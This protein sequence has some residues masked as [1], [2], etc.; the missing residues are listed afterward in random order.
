MTSHEKA[1]T[2]D[3]SPAGRGETRAPFFMPSPVRV[4][5]SAD[6]AGV[7]PT[8]RRLNVGTGL[9]LSAPINLTI[10][11]LTFLIFLHFAFGLSYLFA[12]PAWE[13]YDEPF[14]FGYAARI[15][16]QGTLPQETDNPVNPERIQPP[17]YY[18]GLAS[19]LSASGSD[20]SAYQFPTM[21]PFFYYSSSGN[22]YALHPTTLS[23]N[24]RRI[25]AALFFSRIVS[26]L[27]SLLGIPLVYLAAKLIWPSRQGL[28]LA[29]AAIFALWPQY[30]FNGSMVTNDG[31]TAV[32]G[33]LLTYT[34]I[35]FQL[36]RPTI[37][38]GLICL[39][40][41]IVG[42]FVK[43]N[44]LTL[45]LPLAI[46]ILLTASPRLI[47]LFVGIGTVAVVAVIALLQTLP[48]ILLPFFKLDAHGETILIALWHRLGSNGKPSLVTDS[49]NYALQ[50]SF[51]LFGWGNIALP[52]WLQLVWIGGVALAFAGLL[53]LIFRQRR[54]MRSI[55]RLIV[56]PVFILVALI[57]GGLA[58]SLF[59]GT[60]HLLPGRYLLPALSAF[61]L[62]LV[63]G[64]SGF[65]K[66]VGRVLIGGTIAGLFVLGVVVPWHFLA[67]F[68]APPPVLAAGEPIP[69]NNP[70]EIAPGAELVGYTVPP[71]VLYP[72][73][74]VAVDVY[75]RATRPIQTDYTVRIEWVGYDGQGYGLKD[76]YP[77]NG[78][79]P[80]S[81]WVPNAIFRDRYT[82][83]V[84]ED[85]PAP[86][87]GHFKITLLTTDFT[88]S[89]ELTE[90]PLAVHAVQ[91]PQLTL[92]NQI[93]ARFGD[94]VLLRSASMQSDTERTLSIDALWQATTVPIED[95]TLFVHLEDSTG[96]PVAQQDEP[97]LGGAFPLSR[98]LANEAVSDHYTL[99][100][101]PTAPAGRYA[102]RLGFFDPKTMLRWPVQ[103]S[104]APDFVELGW[105]W[106]DEN[107]NLQVHQHYS[108]RQG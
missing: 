36:K 71:A 54:T 79:H 3:P 24:A 80:T 93:D 75:W 13:A 103:N 20:V 99:V 1:L 77:R 4:A 53:I 51:G 65:G 56:V 97:P 74:E 9:A 90:T 16:S 19:L 88:G 66:R 7:V 58:L 18:L 89:A 70:R 73:D 104:T 92:P 17:L 27:F 11:V 91:S 5:L 101:P 60:I 87:L 45:V 48:A 95:R 55:L 25:E 41:I 94:H 10:G 28:A 12:A 100:L 47:A 85:F 82:L 34:L 49:L 105:V 21:Y 37:R 44:M 40:V 106:L 102:V 8:K 33:A 67:E 61:S 84:R 69:N 64:W 78:N 30:L 38:L 43:L 76:T 23:P 83:N 81:N 52:S 35:R 50:S 68:Y 72:G 107:G 98:W 62:L 96:K 46:V 39:A 86:G 26:L 32:L 14:H 31:P 29:T 63:M 59:Y 15:A 42:I 108:G 6:N 22:N 2:P 57:G